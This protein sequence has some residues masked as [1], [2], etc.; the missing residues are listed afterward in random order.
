MRIFFN[1]SL[2]I[3]LFLK[4]CFAGWSEVARN[5]DFTRYFIDF[6]KMQVVEPY[7]LCLA[8]S[9]LFRARSIGKYE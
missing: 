3:L 9:K 6:G 1:F 5:N 2:V 4:P 7:K 8:F